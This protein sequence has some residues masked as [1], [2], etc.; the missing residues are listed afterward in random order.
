MK[1]QDVFKCEECGA[2]FR[3]ADALE[4]HRRVHERGNDRQLETGTSPPLENPSM[5]PS[6]FDTPIRSS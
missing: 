1:T 5:P 4:K 2:T 3:D 6:G